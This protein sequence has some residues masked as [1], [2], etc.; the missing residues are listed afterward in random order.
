MTHTPIPRPDARYGRPRLSRRARRRVAIALGVLVAAAGIVIAV[1]GYQ[2][3]S[4]SA[5]T[6]SLVGYRLVDD[7]TASVTIS[8][9]RSDPSRPVACIVRVRATNGSETGRR[10]LLVP[11]SEATTVQVTTTVKSSQPPVM[12]DVYGCGTEVPSYLRLPWPWW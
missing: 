1:I 3:I 5:V 10:E 2:R 11:P 6:G 8:V 4:T 12:A 7:E 9:T